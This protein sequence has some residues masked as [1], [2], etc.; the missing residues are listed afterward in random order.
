MVDNRLQIWMRCAIGDA[1]VLLPIVKG[2]IEHHNA[3]GCDLVVTG[4]C[5][6][7][8][9]RELFHM[10]DLNYS[11]LKYTKCNATAKPWFQKKSIHIHETNNPKID[12][13]LNHVQRLDKTIMVREAD[14]IHSEIPRDYKSV[15][16]TSSDIVIPWDSYVIF[17]PFGASNPKYK[18]KSVYNT[19]QRLVDYYLAHT[20]HSIVFTGRWNDE[21]PEEYK[22]FQCGEADKLRLNYIYDQTTLSDMVALIKRAD[23][24]V[25]FDSGMKNFG[26]IYGRKSIVVWDDSHPNSMPLGAWCPS[27]F[28]NDVIYCN[29][30][31]KIDPDEDFILEEFLQCEEI[32]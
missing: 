14:Y 30:N 6:P 28:H 32:L 18:S 7:G 22:N 5:S 16:Y 12:L 4:P 3:S 24:G 13:A 9:I 27:Q 29:V 15:K 31:N 10:S 1:L 8:V 23:S 19:Y 11:S 2:A 25:Y 20:N 17:C 26:F 21:I